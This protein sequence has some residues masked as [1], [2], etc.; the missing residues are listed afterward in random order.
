VRYYYAPGSAAAHDRAVA[1]LGGGA[2]PAEPRWAI[3]RPAQPYDLSTPGTPGGILDVARAAAAGGVWQARATFALAASPDGTEI[4]ASLCLRLAGD[5]PGRQR[6]AW[7]VYVRAE[8]GAAPA[9]WKPNG[10]GLL[11][12]GDPARPLR[13]IGINELKATLRGEEWRPP[14]PRPGPPR[15]RCYTCDKPTPFST[16]TWRPYARHRCDPAHVEG[17]S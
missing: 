17:R 8:G 7:A 12:A 6:R 3:L 14:P 16:T 13:T 11:D 1:E 9:V 10:A 4:V 2:T 15:L 5:L